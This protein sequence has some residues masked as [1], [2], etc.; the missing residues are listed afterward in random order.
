MRL[1]IT[2]PLKWAQWW[3]YCILIILVNFVVILPLASFLFHD[4]YS[5]LIPTDTIQ[6]IP[7]SSSKLDEHAK[8]NGYSFLF[9]I[10]RHDTDVVTLPR[11][12]ENGLEQNIPLRS[13]IPY[14][15]DIK[16]KAFCLNNSPGNNIKT[17]MLTLRVISPKTFTKRILFQRPLLLTCVNSKDV[18][19]LAEAGALTPNFAYRLQKDLV[20][21]FEKDHCAMIAHDVKKIEVSILMRDPATLLVDS[22]ASELRL[23][24]DLKYSPRNIML[25]WKKLSYIVGILTF[26][27]VILFFF[28]IA[29]IISFWR[30]KSTEVTIDKYKLN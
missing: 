25:R 3:I 14:D 1:N 2:L 18:Y 23:A 30:I 4:F 15:V 8:E 29:F 22:A 6:T 5:R 20:N 7:F 19:A 16:L 11:L 28:S 10:Q 24:M 12:L 27:G 13:D 26:H 17:A 9:D 21:R